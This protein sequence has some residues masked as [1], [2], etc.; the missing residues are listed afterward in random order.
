[1]AF[2]TSSA[3]SFTAAWQVGVSNATSSLILGNG[4]SYAVTQIDG[5]GMPNVDAADGSRPREQGDMVG[6]DFLGGR[7]ITI[8]GDVT[9]DGTSLQHALQALAKVTTTTIGYGGVEYPLW[10]NVPNLVS[11]GV[12]T[13]LAAMVRPRKRDIPFDLAHT[14]GLAS[15]ALQ[16]S[17]TDPR[18]YT[19]SVTASRT[20]TGAI[21]ITNAGNYETRPIYTVTGPIN[22][23]WT[24]SN[25]TATITVNKALTSGSTLV[26]DSDFHTATYT[27][28]GG[29]A[30]NGRGYLGASPGWWS[31]APGT[32]TVTLAG[33]GASGSTALSASYSSAWM[34]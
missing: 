16:F 34:L 6:I 27:P 4:T 24:L 26:L 12:N 9:A 20:N 14:A 5:I 7:D 31:C 18:W 33:S 23:G 22:T 2:P 19:A 32:T 29:G 11:V 21:T 17:A 30:T 28:S 10:I 1:M 15:Y 13:P 8:T 3:P 25:G